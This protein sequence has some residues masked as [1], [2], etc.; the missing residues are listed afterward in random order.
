M[1]WLPQFFS[2]LVPHQPENVQRY[3]DFTVLRRKSFLPFRQKQDFLPP[4]LA[5]AS[6]CGLNER[7]NGEAVE[8][9]FYSKCPYL[10][11]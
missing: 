7:K 5:Q 3:P 1:L 4:A 2:I 6:V 8:N 9:I 10:I 11:G